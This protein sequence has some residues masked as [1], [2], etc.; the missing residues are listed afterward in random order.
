[1]HRSR[2]SIVA[3]L[4]LVEEVAVSLFGLCCFLGRS[5]LD[6]DTSLFFL[7]LAFLLDCDLSALA[8]TNSAK[9]FTTIEVTKLM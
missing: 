5:Q 8:I 6:E 7:E 9:G 2:F 1:M 4:A 3:V